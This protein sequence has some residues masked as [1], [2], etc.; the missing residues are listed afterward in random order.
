MKT[1]TKREQESLYQIKQNLSQKL[2]WDKISLYND[3]G[4]I[5]QEDITI[6]NICSQHQT[7]TSL[8]ICK[9]NNDRSEE[10]AI[11]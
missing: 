2:S 3:K 1:V 5:Q 11:Q 8:L 10:I 4:S 9:A 6:I 7:Q